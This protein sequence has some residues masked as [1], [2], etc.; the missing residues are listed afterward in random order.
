MTSME[1]I[2]EKLDDI[3]KKLLA[4][5]PE[6]K[7]AAIVSIEGLPI[8]SAFPQGDDETRIAALV[9]ALFSLAKESVIEMK[10]GGFD[11]LHIN[12]T[13]GYLLVMQAGPNG[14][15][16]ISTT[17]ELRTGSFL[18]LRGRYIPPDFPSGGAIG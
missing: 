8:A 11:Q 1:P 15:L 13:E 14:I 10:K 9:S 16:L 17:K 3:L 7:A 6:I 18:N 4:A 2:S 12:G 5:I